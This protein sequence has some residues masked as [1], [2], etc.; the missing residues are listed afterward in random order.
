M[1]TR[2]MQTMTGEWVDAYLKEDVEQRLSEVEAERD[3]L[4]R[5]CSKCGLAYQGFL[6]DTEG[7]VICFDSFGHSWQF[8]EPRLDRELRTLRADQEADA[9]GA[10]EP[11]DRREPAVRP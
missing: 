7:T 8:D 1:K 4:L 2:P 11:E 9:R 6:N 5:H 3:N 10:E